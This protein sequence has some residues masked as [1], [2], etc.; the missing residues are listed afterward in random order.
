MAKIDYIF[1]EFE[2]SIICL[3]MNGLDYLYGLPN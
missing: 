1:G 3:K 2:V